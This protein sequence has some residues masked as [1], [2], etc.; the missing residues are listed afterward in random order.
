MMHAPSIRSPYRA[1]PPSNGG[2]MISTTGRALPLLGA[3]VSADAAGG[4]AR[5]TVEQRFQNP[6]AEPLAVTYSL[7]LPSDGAVS[8]FSFRV[9]GRRVVGEIDRKRAARERYEQA[10][11]EGHSAALLE[12]DRSSLFT[13]EIGNIPPGEEVT[14]EVSIDQ[15]LRWL[16][17]RV[18]GS[19]AS[20]PSSA[21]ATW[22][23]PAGCPM[24]IASPRTWRPDRWTP[25][26]RSR[27]RSAIPPRTACGRSR[28]RTPSRPRPSAPRSA[29]GSGT[30]RER[31]SIATWWCAGGWRRRRWGSRS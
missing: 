16:S 29:S 8:G 27:A 4:V 14:V 9:G 20:P 12:Q 1:A 23:S 26:S 13:Q 22:A 28:R 19:G 3:T 5:V 11:M 31:A 24:P 17:T 15:R 10:L 2:R 7:P 25:A 18:P 30:G 6:Y 21:R